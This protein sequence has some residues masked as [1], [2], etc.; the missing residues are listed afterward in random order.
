MQT[1][2]DKGITYNA[3]LKEI[4]RNI[5]KLKNISINM[6][7]IEK[8]IEE[9]EKEVEQKIKNN[10]T[11][12]QNNSSL[13]FLH[14]SLDETYINAQIYP[15]IEA[16]TEHLKGSVPTKEEIWK[17][18]SDVVSNVNNKLPNYKHIK[19]FGIRDKEFEKT[20]TKKL[21]V[22]EIT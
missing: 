8:T 9:I 4:K 10:Y 1:K 14:D 22:M 20:T 3:K 21:N 13:N 11:L 16:I 12:F 6:Q 15:N 17:I 7:L 19:S 5:E 18:V 2:Y